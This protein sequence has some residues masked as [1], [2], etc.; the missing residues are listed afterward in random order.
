MI[1]ITLQAL[2]QNLSETRHP[3]TTRQ[4]SLNVLVTVSGGY[5][6]SFFS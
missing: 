3:G 2:F 1:K 5:K 4:I 6:A